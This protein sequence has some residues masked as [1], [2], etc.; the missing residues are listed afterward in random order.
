MVVVVALFMGTCLVIIVKR[1][2]SKET[3]KL[4]V[5][6]QLIIHHV[7]QVLRLVNDVNPEV[8][9]QLQTLLQLL[10]KCKLDRRG[11]ELVQEVLQRQQDVSGVVERMKR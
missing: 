2:R 7:T 9:Q 5:Y 11:E 6:I 3:S 4:W 10:D 8:G 1:R